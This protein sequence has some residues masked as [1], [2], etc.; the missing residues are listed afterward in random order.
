MQAPSVVFIFL[1][2]YAVT[3]L[4]LKS[5]PNR[6]LAGF[7]MLFNVFIVALCVFGLVAAFT[8]KLEEPIKATIGSLLLLMTSGLNCKVLVDQWERAR[9]AAQR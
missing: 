4:A 5:T 3:L 9:I 1:A 8:G 6:T 2:P 7:G